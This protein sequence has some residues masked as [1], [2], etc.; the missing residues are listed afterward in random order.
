MLSESA[1][2]LSDG[3]FP[4]WGPVL[5][6]GPPPHAAR[7][8][9]CCSAAGTGIATHAVRCGARTGDLAEPHDA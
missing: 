3:Y 2:M 9:G 6:V 7:A 1:V 4:K 5:Q 8:R